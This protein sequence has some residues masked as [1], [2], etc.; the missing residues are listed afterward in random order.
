MHFGAGS[1]RKTPPRVDP[2][3]GYST[4]TDSPA[5]GRWFQ[6]LRGGGRGLKIGGIKFG[7]RSQNT[8]EGQ[9]RQAVGLGVPNG[10]RVGRANTF[11]DCCFERCLVGRHVS[12]K[13][14]CSEHQPQENSSVCRRSKLLLF[15]ISTKNSMVCSLPH[16]SQR[17]RAKGKKLQM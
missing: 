10:F 13:D 6:K 16:S 1:R 15:S 2:L 3:D 17:R 5:M 12:Y 7:G 14:A 11:R 4:H 8:S 9:V